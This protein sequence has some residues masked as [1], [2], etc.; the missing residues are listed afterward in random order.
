[1]RSHHT[2]AAS[3]TA[4]EVEI[5]T[6]GTGVTGGNLLT[7]TVPAGVEEGDIILVHL[8][9]IASHVVTPQESGWTNVSF[10][11]VPEPSGVYY[12]EAPAT[13]PTSYTFTRSDTVGN[14]SG[15]L[16]VIKAPAYSLSVSDLQLSAFNINSSPPVFSFSNSPG[17][18]RNIVFF[19]V[20]W[21]QNPTSITLNDTNF[22]L[23]TSGSGTL[24]GGDARMYTQVLPNNEPFTSIN[25]GVQ[26]TGTYSGPFGFYFVIN[27]QFPR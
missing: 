14:F 12:R 20:E 18:G 3:F 22:S 21:L 9:R 6:G 15:Y 26:L 19:G 11:L 27:S 25:F 1:M 2:R 24:T 23:L 17:R 7:L 8:K 4:P 5:I 10:S 13:P 16:I